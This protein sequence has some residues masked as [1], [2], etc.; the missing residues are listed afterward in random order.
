MSKNFIIVAPPFSARSGG[1]MVLHDLCT[2]LNQIGEQASIVFIHGGSQENQNFKFGYSSDV[3]L[4][5]PNG[6]YFDFFNGRSLSEILAYIGDSFV[7]YPDIVKGNP[8]GAKRFGTYVLG[9]PKINIDSPF[10]IS[11]SNRYI[12]SYDC[13][14][15]KPFISEH[16]HARDTVHWTK[17]SLSLSY[18]G[19]G[20]E[21]E[22]CIPLPG[23]ILVERDWPRDKNQLA[24]LLRQCKYFFTWDCLSATNLDAVLCGAVPIFMQHKQLSRTIIDSLE[25]G[26]F[27]SLYYS[28]G[29]DI[30]SN[31]P[32][33]MDIDGVMCDMV[34]KL[35]SY[36]VQWLE[37]VANFVEILKSKNI[38]D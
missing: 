33:I 23:T 21:Y 14:L 11:Y 20:Y 35:H 10:V 34:Y 31:P 28:S 22:N 30:R 27:P 36:S 15:Y 13:I 37:S 2:A 24:L 6:S 7:I 5:D 1:V 12:N 17:R 8:L 32:E 25:P 9:F 4:Y 19:K 26:P 18:V 16:M 38:C 3:H 29:F